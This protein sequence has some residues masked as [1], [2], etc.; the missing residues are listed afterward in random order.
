MIAQSVL[1][2]P[3]NEEMTEHIAGQA[4]TRQLGR[5]STKSPQDGLLTMV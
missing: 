2:T 5:G 3:L 1:E 4:G